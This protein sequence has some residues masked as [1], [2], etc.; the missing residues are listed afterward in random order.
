M[1]IQ[2]PTFQPILN[3]DIV[4][5]SDAKIT[6]VSLLLADTEY[7]HVLVN[8]LKELR[9]KCREY[10]D[11]KYSFVSGESDTKYFTIWR[12]VCDNLTDLDFNNKTL[13]IQSSRANVTVEVMELY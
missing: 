12:G 11:L 3:V 6:N 1:T 9:I 5:A 2:Q 7:S 4:N 13:F 10:A 8:G